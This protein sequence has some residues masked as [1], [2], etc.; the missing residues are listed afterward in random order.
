MHA[1]SKPGR[2]CRLASEVALREFLGDQYQHTDF[3]GPCRLARLEVFKNQQH[4]CVAFTDTLLDRVYMYW[5]L[6]RDIFVTGFI[7]DYTR[8]AGSQV[9]SL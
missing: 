5:A 7:I 3:T 9:L 1:R 4:V 2:S 6:K 8:T